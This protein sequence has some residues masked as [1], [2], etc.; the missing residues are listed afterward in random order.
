M[1]QYLGWRAAESPAAEQT[2]GF[3]EVPDAALT[4]VKSHDLVSVANY[5]GE[6]Q[7]NSRSS[8]LF[9]ASCCLRSQPSGGGLISGLC[10]L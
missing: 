2:D 10:P 7:E 8:P 6:R 5:W 3:A 4:S 9:A 1:D